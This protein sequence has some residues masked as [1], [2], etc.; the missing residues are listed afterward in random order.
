ML[1]KWVD[2][3]GNEFSAARLSLAIA[4]DDIFLAEGASQSRQRVQKKARWG[5]TPSSPDLRRGKVVGGAEL[6]VIT[7]EKSNFSRI[8]FVI[9]ALPLTLI[10][11][12][13]PVALALAGLLSLASARAAPPAPDRLKSECDMIIVSKADAYALTPDLEDDAKIDA[14]WQRLQQMIQAGTA[15]PVAHLL[16]HTAL[17]QRSRIETIEEMRYA[18]EFEP[19]E[20]LKGQLAA[21]ARAT[22]SA[23]HLEPKPDEPET[24]NVGQTLELEISQERE[25]GLLTINLVAEHTRF[26]RWQSY[27]GGR[28]PNGE[29]F[30]YR[31]PVFHTMRSQLGFPLRA[32]RRLLIAMHRVPD[33]PKPAFELIFFRAT[34]EKPAGP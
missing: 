33:S 3:H 24:R 27:D 13:K 18:S 26:L 5:E 8:P 28:L 29:T 1:A 30:A 11:S 22:K 9:P 31:Q 21:H 23:A 19:P 12:M 15:T 17:N 10:P 20:F 2:F 34:L 6:N 7:A 4:R 32:G 16:G 14:G 25:P